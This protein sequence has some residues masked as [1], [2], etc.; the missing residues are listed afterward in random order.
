MYNFLKLYGLG[1]LIMV[2][3][4]NFNV[5]AFLKISKLLSDGDIESNPGPTYEILKAVQGS[6]NQ[7]H[8][9]FGSGMQCACNSLFSICWSTLRR[10]AI[11]K[12]TDLD[13]ILIKG[14]NCYQGELTSNTKSTFLRSSFTRSDRG[15][16]LL[17]MTSGYTFCIIWNKNN[18]FLFDPHSRNYNGAFTVNGTST[19]L[20]FSSVIQLYY[21]LL[22]IK[23]IWFTILP[24]SICY[25]LLK[26]LYYKEIRNIDLIHMFLL[27]K[28]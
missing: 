18:Y 8:P 23:T 24:N 12:N 4:C 3:I 17:F 7:G 15:D 26:M 9:Q 5:A 27:I 1:F 28:K 21:R 14:E 19:L 6:F 16:G 22:S 10:V 11:W 20:K 25:I 2:I 13:Y